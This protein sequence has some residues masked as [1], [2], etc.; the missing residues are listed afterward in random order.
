MKVE[1]TT[2]QRSA[3]EKRGDNVLLAAAAGSGKTAVLVQRIIELVSKEELGREAVDVNRLLVLTFTE[4]AATEMRGK[5][6]AAVSHALSENPD[7]P[8][9]QKQSLLMH[10]ASISTIHA[11]CL[12]ILK[13]NIHLTDLPV[14]FTLV[15]EIENKIILKEAMDAVLEK[16]YANIEKN[17]AFKNLVLGYGGIKN[18]IGIRDTI[19]SLLKFSKS[20]PYPAKWLNKSIREYEY[21][22]KNH[23][24]SETYIKQIKNIIEEYKN[25]VLEI[26][27]GILKLE[28]QHL[29]KDHPYV[30]FFAAERENFKGLFDG[31]KEK[32]YGDIQ[33]MLK[34]FELPRLVSGEKKA[35]GFVREAQENIKAYRDAAKKIIV[36]LKKLLSVSEEDLLQRISGIY[37]SLRTL[38]NIVLTVD[39]RYTREKRRRNYLD[40]NDLE[41]EALKLLA[42]ENGT[43]TETALRL[44]E[45][46]EE[47]LIDEYQDTN[48]I[49]DT[50]FRVLSRDNT[51]VFMVGDLKQSI[52]KFRNAVPALFSEKYDSY[53]DEKNSGELIKL[54]KNF[55]SRDGVVNTINFIFK[56]I[57]SKEVGDLEYDESEYLVRGAEYPE[58]VEEKAMQTELHMICRDGEL[59]EDFDGKAEKDKFVLE[60][61]TAAS[62]ICQ[63]IGDKTQVFDKKKQILRDAEY[64]DIVILMRNTGTTAPV[65][66]KVLS[67]WNIPVYTDVGRSYLSSTEV[68]TVL[69]YLQIID[70]PKQDIPLIAVMRSAMWGFTAE[71]LAKIRMK[72]R[73]GCFYDALKISA[74]E[75]FHKAAEF[76]NEL[77]KMRSE[78]EYVGVDKLIWKIYYEFG[79]FAYSGAQSRGRER[80]AN[81]RLLFERAS[82]FER[83]KL[84]GLFSF[85]NYIETI[86]SE[87]ADLSPASIFGEDE[88]VV[89]IMSIHKSK[90]LEFPIV[91]LADV[92]HKFNMTDAG[93]NIIW[94]EALGIGA[95]YV[96]T[97]LRVRYPSLIRNIIS[98]K[99][100]TEAMSEEMRLL[101]VALTRAREKLIIVSSFKNSEKNWKAPMLDEQGRALGAYVKGSSCF[102]DWILCALMMHPDAKALRQWCERDEKG[103]DNTA[104]F[105]L[106][107]KIYE[108]C[109]MVPD[110]KEYGCFGEANHQSSESMD[111]EKI[112]EKLDYEY[113]NK[114]LGEIPVKMSVSEVKRIESS[115]EEY[116][117][118]IE[119]LGK[120]G[121]L[122]VK[123]ISGAE[124]GTVIHFIMQM[125]DAN[126][127]KGRD[128][129]SRLVERLVA[130]K[131]ISKKMAD[132]VDCAQ[133]AEFYNGPLGERMR[134]AVRVEKEFSFYTEEVAD[135]IYKNGIF[136]KILLQGTIDCFFVEQ[137]GK[138]VLIDFKTDRVAGKEAAEKRAES[139]KVQMKYYIKGLG[140]ILK[141]TVDECYLYFLN[142]G[143][144]VKIEI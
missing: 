136:S 82:E 43:P 15:S 90:G 46:Y 100:K 28:D 2:E 67:E 65:F 78:A 59:P 8:H 76:L 138:V 137:D 44:R 141:R 22:Y 133:I 29:S 74:E 38:K 58:N 34:A 37:P 107:V 83:T 56:R 116:V 119:E 111:E 11:F 31:M 109:L 4:A 128:D 131:V 9:L 18:D 89:R 110:A 93:Q 66:E 36:N 81:L 114:A 102:R 48:N 120:N 75:G 70:N 127:I 53:A 51:N 24:L 142:C 92:S 132:S 13:N 1:W 139:Y 21:T 126:A 47:I 33:S 17:P 54:F 85:M 122:K 144:T 39:R 140:E 113:P 27:D 108:N 25:N 123:E 129:V 91:I 64:R 115:G 61:R 86:R 130:E 96:D 79:Y 135:E 10:S 6:S 57:M 45:K 84:S 63:I 20:M 97:K 112:L 117:P 99:A 23:K 49:Q 95:D 12:N 62:R 32:G 68:Q 5:I 3:I 77:H 134:K 7:N 19:L 14:G 60:A 80:Q 88:N 143:Q 26:Y 104:D 73:S 118:V 87:G 40:F 103:V 41:H 42:D 105:D 52:Y 71:E 106:F 94:H 98:E 124:R 16:Y 50:I 55:R 125:A 101:Y 121:L 69:A 72:K 35:E 30:A